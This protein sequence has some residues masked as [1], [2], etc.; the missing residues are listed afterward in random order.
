M[1]CNFENK[2]EL[3]ADNFDLLIIADKTRKGN[4]TG[5]AQICRIKNSKTQS[6]FILDAPQFKVGRDMYYENWRHVRR[7]TIQREDREHAVEGNKQDFSKID[8]IDKDTRSR[9]SQSYRKMYG[10]DGTSFE[11]GSLTPGG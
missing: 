5:E 4:R 9:A 7:F 10:D 1:V 6:Y 11:K 8:W 3:L 2:M